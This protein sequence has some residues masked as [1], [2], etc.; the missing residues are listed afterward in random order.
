MKE[1]H[2]LGVMTAYNRLN[3]PFCSEH[4]PLITEILR[5]E[6]GFEGLVMT[7]W[8]SGGSTVAAARAGLDVEMP[9]PGSRFFGAHLADAVRVGDVGP[10]LVHEQARRILTTLD[11]VGALD[12]GPAGEEESL[13]RPEHRA[14]AREAAAA[15]MVLLRNDG[16]LP[17]D[18]ASI[19]TVA[20]I[21]PNAARVQMMGG[22]SAALAPHYRAAPLDALRAAF[23][24]VRYERGCDIARWTEALGPPGVT[25]PDGSP[26]FA[27]EYYAG[28]TPTGPARRRRTV[29]DAVFLTLGGP[30]ESVSTPFSM[31][32]AGR[33]TPSETGTHTLTLAQ[34]A[35]TARLLVDGAV[36]LDGGTAPDAGREFFGLLSAELTVDLDLVAGRAYEVV[37][38]YVAPRAEFLLGAFVGCRLPSPP[39]LLDRAVRAAAA[40]DVAIVIVGTNAGWETEGHDRATMQLPGPQDELVARVADANPRTA[41][42]VNTGSPVSMDWADAAAAVVQVWFGGQEM[43]NAIVD[44][45][46]GAADPGGRLPTTIPKRLEDNPSFGNFPGER[47]EVRYGE[48]LLIGYRWYDARRLAPRYPFGHGLSYTTFDIGAPAPT[49]TTLTVGKSLQVRVPVTNTGSRRGSVVVQCYVAPVSPTLTRP[50]KEL[51]AFQKLTLDPGQTGVADLEPRATGVRV[52]GPGLGPR[53]RREPRRRDGTQRRRPPDGR[54]RRGLARRPRRAPNPDRTLVGRHRPHRHRRARAVTGRGGSGG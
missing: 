46:T 27:V 10:E 39:D 6:W 12:D 23:D 7:D 17:L 5:G 53:G 8:Y 1:G 15:S 36:V 29:P 13:D 20:V 16:L 26:G 41:V 24:D 21:G 42:L 47:G 3:G 19:G 30:P 34:A 51:K 38:E 52:L 43:A 54:G 45:L 14:L 18:P 44:V 49:A 22:G 28:A 2:T 32:A 9:G 11:R 33:F 40:A 35:G 31:R 37:V 4:R 48:G 25:Q 50:P